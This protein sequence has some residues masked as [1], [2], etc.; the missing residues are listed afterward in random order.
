MW[1]KETA[2]I[3]GDFRK[4]FG[5]LPGTLVAVAISSDS[6]DT[7]AQILAAVADLDVN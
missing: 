3:R 2:D 6:D 5:R 1:F 4:A 7:G